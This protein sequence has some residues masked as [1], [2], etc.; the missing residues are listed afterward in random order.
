MSSW[1]NQ[2]TDNDDPYNGRGDRI[3]FNFDSGGGKDQF[4]KYLE[5]YRCAGYLF[6][7]L[8]DDL[9]RK[10]LIRLMAFWA[11]GETKIRLPL[12]RENYLEALSRAANYLTTDVENPTIT[13]GEYTLGC[14]DM[15]LA[16]INQ[17]LYASP[18][19]IG[20]VWFLKQYEYENDSVS[21]KVEEGD[22]VIDCGGCWGDTSLY[23]ADKVGNNGHVFVFEFIPSHLKVINCNIDLNPQ[24]KNRLTLVPNPV[25][26]TT[27]DKLYFV[28][29]GP[30]SRLSS[31]PNRYDYDGTTHT[32]SIDDLVQKNNISKVDFIKMDIEGAETEAL[33]GAEKTLIRDKPKLAISIYHSLEDFD[34]IPAYLDSLG[35]GYSFY[36][37]DHTLYENETVLY[38]VQ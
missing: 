11:M 36:L 5:Q 1:T 20:S 24:L 33:K 18:P 28:D 8:N 12:N 6:S 37:R 38:A 17:K 30:G 23:F 16:G 9:S 10:L 2:L 21:C 19:G 25:W 15:N 7:I 32:L 35:L 22:T 14:Y 3:T 4:L 31:D 27:G 13:S 34:R 26:S 29:W